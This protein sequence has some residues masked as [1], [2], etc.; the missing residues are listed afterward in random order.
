M[1]R[2]TSLYHRKC[3]SCNKI[4]YYSCLQSK[5]QSDI[6]NKKCNS[7]TQ[8]GRK[9]S[10]KTKLKMSLQRRGRKGIPHT[11]ETKKKL[12]LLRMGKKLSEETKKKLSVLWS[13]KRNPKYKNGDKI[14]G[15]KNPFYGR[16]HTKET[17]GKISK[18]NTGRKWTEDRKQ[19]QRECLLRKLESQN[20]VSFNPIACRFIDEYGK[21]QGYNF[22]HALNGGEKQ[23]IGYKLDGYDEKRNMI[24]EYDEPDHETKRKK[25][26][27]LVRLKNLINHLKCK[28]IRYSEKCNVIYESYPEF[29]VRVF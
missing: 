2:K 6:Y 4:L 13:G 12:S 3:P 20:I 16:S 5:N 23:I 17:L 10:E 7:C 19:K 26:K 11:D 18:A 15:N 29:S 1:K 28:V 14:K 21:Q 27:D 9:A 24:F 22:Q 8:I 25:T